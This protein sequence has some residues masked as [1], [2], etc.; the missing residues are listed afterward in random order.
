MGTYLLPESIAR[1]D[2]SGAEIALEKAFGKPLLIRL[3]I[4]RIVEHESLDVS[5]WGSPDR[6]GW[7]KLAA[8]P[9]KSYCGVYSMVLDLERH[10]EVRYL[11]ADWRMGCLAHSDDPEPLFGFYVL[12]EEATLHAVGA[13]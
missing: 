5:L 8:F 9:Q 2:G 7:K 6:Q 12:M 13:T 3:G 4:T 10:P 1:Q 11:R